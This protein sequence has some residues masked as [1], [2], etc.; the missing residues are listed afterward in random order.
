MKTH[1]LSRSREHTAKIESTSV[2]HIGPDGAVVLWAITST[3][4][5]SGDQGADPNKL[6]AIID[7]LKNTN[8]TVAAHERFY[9]LRSAGFAE[10][11]RGGF[12]YAGTEMARRGRW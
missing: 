2:G 11:L 3:V 12:L 6:V 10:V 8:P 4:S 1:E 7:N 9:N 5:G